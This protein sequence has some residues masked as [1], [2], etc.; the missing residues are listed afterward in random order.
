[1]SHETITIR[2]AGPADRAA[3]ERLAGRD[4]TVLTVDEYLIAEVERCA[5]VPRLARQAA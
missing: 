1:M 5:P 3:L 4:S 2:R